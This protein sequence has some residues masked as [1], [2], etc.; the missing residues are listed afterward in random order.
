MSESTCNSADDE[1]MQDNTTSLS[2]SLHSTTSGNGQVQKTNVFSSSAPIT[3]THQYSLS[4]TSTSTSTSTHQN[5]TTTT[6]TVKTKKRGKPN[7]PCND[8]FIQFAVF[9][10]SILCFALGK[11]KQMTVVNYVILNSKECDR[12][13]RAMSHFVLIAKNKDDIPSVIALYMDVNKILGLYGA[14]F[15]SPNEILH[16]RWTTNGIC[17]DHVAQ[18]MACDTPN[19]MMSSRPSIHDLELE[20]M[21]YSLFWGYTVPI[22]KSC[23]SVFD[24]F[25]NIP[26]RSLEY[27]ERNSA[28]RS[29]VYYY[30]NPHVDDTDAKVIQDFFTFFGDKEIPFWLPLSLSGKEGEEYHRQRL[31]V[32]LDNIM[33]HCPSFD[34]KA[35]ETLLMKALPRSKRRTASG[36][37][38]E[39]VEILLELNS[40]KTKS[41]K[42]RIFCLEKRMFV[43]QYGRTPLD[44]M[45]FIPNFTLQCLKYLFGVISAAIRNSNLP[46]IM[47]VFFGYL[48]DSENHT[49][50]KIFSVD[51][52]ILVMA[53]YRLSKCKASRD[54]MDENI[55]LPPF[56]ATLR[57]DYCIKFS[58]C[59]FTYVFLDSMDQPFVFCMKVA[60]DCIGYLYN[61]SRD[62]DK[63]AEVQS[64]LN[65]FVGLM[66]SMAPPHFSNPS[67]MNSAYIWESLVA[68]GDAKSSDCFQNETSLRLVKGASK[69]S[70]NEEKT[71][72]KRMQTLEVIATM[73][74]NIPIPHFIEIV[75]HMN[76][77]EEA[78]S[79]LNNSFYYGLL[80]D[81]SFWLD[82]LIPHK[83]YLDAILMNSQSSWRNEHPIIQDLKITETIWAQSIR[84]EGKKLSSADFKHSLTL[85]YILN[86]CEALAITRDYNETT[87]LFLVCGFVCKKVK[88]LDSSFVY[89]MA[90]CLPLPVISGNSFFSTAHYGFLK[91]E[92]LDK[93]STKNIIPISL[94]R[95]KFNKVIPK[96]VG[97]KIL[98]IPYETKC[99]R[100]TRRL[101]RYDIWEKIKSII[102]F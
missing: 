79:D 49:P 27:L 99:I 42:S 70:P 30:Y 61:C 60:L 26:C 58:L 14:Y 56:Y 95:L 73:I 19:K 5:S 91:A 33:E 47:E 98:Y 45:H 9:M 82:N 21:R 55:I 87:R 52:N 102:Y 2:D 38:D 59:Y 43:A 67:I 76:S 7:K 69:P 39:I 29:A 12:N 90:L 34:L 16:I 46:S 75:T 64:I 65:F 18:E 44:L 35:L 86:N 101:K 68:F 6:T 77:M 78:I 92:G 15:N 89:P 62:L 32:A 4:S 97:K 17:G 72:A 36:N 8:H 71:V 83:T 74:D 20:S 51:Q 94:F 80:D 50:L 54:W 10:D 25:M 57:N 3:E 66:Q 1:V 85:K 48:H 31:H 84:F 81:Y 22:N 96:V 40:D 88:T 28:L 100:Q 23:Y 41:E 63:A 24:R 13:S 11:I 53:Y 93:L 37:I